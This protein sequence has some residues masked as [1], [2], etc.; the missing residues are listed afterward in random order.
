MSELASALT[1]AGELASV[2]TELVEAKLKGVGAKIRITLTEKTQLARI[3]MLCE[4][5]GNVLSAHG[6]PNGG[7]EFEIWFGG[8]N[9]EPEEVVEMIADMLKSG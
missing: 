5:L 8:R 6:V 3:A 2:V 7:M 4:E 1:E 9:L